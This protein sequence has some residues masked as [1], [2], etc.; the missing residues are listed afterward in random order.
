MILTWS[1][2]KWTAARA[3]VPADA[4][5][6]PDATV[7]GMSC[8]SATWCTA[9]GQYTDTTV[10]GN[11][12]L[13]R[14]SGKKWTATA[15][16]VP[17]GA[18]VD[19]SLNAVSCPSVTRC[20]AGG[21]HEDALFQTQPLLLSWS[22]SKWTLVRVPLPAGAATDPQADVYAV[23]C[24]SVTRCFATGTY[25]DSAGNQQGVLLSW[26]GKKWT[27]TRAPVPAGAASNP[28]TSPFAVS[29]A[30]STHCT[31][32]GSYSGASNPALGLLLTWSGKKWTAATAPAIAYDL[33]GMSCPTTTRCVAVSWGIGRPVGLTGP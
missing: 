3:A 19:A 14:L 30:S 25:L 15:A 5:V 33:R 28:F 6:N 17:A 18:P 21:T 13:L 8:R 10:H 26:S 24:P 2:T 32:S 4:G 9:V 31:A 22:G 29:C 7:S 23:S 16:P 12:V 1:G 20:F 27:A 11:G